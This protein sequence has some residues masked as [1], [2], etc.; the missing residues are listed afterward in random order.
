MSLKGPGEHRYVPSTSIK[1]DNSLTIRVG[2]RGASEIL[3]IYIYNINCIDQES[4]LP[5]V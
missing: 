2:E 3:G 4:L 1:G 5:T